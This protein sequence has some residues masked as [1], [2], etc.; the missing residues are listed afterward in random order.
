MQVSPVRVEEVLSRVLRS[1]VLCV[2]EADALRVDT[3]YILQDGHLLRV[4][5]EQNGNADG[6]TVSDGG[7][8]TTQIETFTRSN[9]A[10][11]RRYARLERIA[12]QLELEWDTEF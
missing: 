12:Q 3:P 11:R 9:A 8:A 2:R 7:Y 4:Y 1:E 5:L 6:I 10:L